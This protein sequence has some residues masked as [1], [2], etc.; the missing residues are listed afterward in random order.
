MY[1][2][3]V[4]YLDAVAPYLSSELVNHR[5]LS[6]IKTISRTLKPTWGAF[7]ECP[8]GEDNSTVHFSTHALKNAIKLP[9]KMRSESIWQRIQQLCMDCNCSQSRLSQEIGSIVL[10]F[11]KCN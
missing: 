9:A 11:D 5:I 8:L 7:L 1:D 4:D 6:R 10:D 3:L 2:Y